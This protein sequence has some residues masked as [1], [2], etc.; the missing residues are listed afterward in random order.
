ML[1]RVHGP[2]ELE[3]THQLCLAV[4]YIGPAAEPVSFHRL[5]PPI[6]TVAVFPPD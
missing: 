6:A 1:A 4:P 2:S 5:R 3:M